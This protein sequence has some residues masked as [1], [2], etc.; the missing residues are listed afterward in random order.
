MKLLLVLVYWFVDCFLNVVKLHQTE[1]KSSYMVH[2]QLS[3]E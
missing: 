1:G 3:S 2:P